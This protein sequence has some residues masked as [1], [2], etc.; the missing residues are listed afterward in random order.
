MDLESPKKIYCIQQTV[1]FPYLK[2]PNR[3]APFLNVLL[4]LTGK[5]DDDNQKKE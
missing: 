4:I 3:E 2:I 5:K 1:I